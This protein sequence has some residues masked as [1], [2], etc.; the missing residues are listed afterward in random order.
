MDVFDGLE[1][2]IVFF[3]PNIVDMSPPI[4]IP[5]NSIHKELIDPFVNLYAIHTKLY[6]ICAHS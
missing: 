5:H 2:N 4:V 1:I 6:K 3:F